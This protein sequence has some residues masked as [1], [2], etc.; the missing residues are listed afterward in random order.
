VGLA[1]A[2]VRVPDFLSGDYP[3]II[4]VGNVASNAASITV[5]VK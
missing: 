2:N 1:Q 5:S 3:P 4:T